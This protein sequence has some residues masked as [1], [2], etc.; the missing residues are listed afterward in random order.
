MTIQAQS[1]IYLALTNNAQLALRSLYRFVK[2][3]QLDSPSFLIESEIKILTRRLS[4]LQMSEISSI[5]SL[6]KEYYNAE[7]AVD[8]FGM[9]L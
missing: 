7:E 9:N 5:A 1:Q 2:F 4:G 3:K 8:S 6:F